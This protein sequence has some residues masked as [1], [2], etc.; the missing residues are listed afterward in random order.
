RRT[1]FLAPGL[2]D[3]DV[4]GRAGAGAAAL[5]LD[6]GNGVLERSFHHGCTDLGVDGAALTSGIDVSDLDHRRSTNREAS[7]RVAGRAS[8]NGGGRRAQVSIRAEP[9]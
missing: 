6:P 3:I 7:D 2:I 5:G 1:G 9:L 4:T 8:Y